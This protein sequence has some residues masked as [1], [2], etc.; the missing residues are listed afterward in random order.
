M[1]CNKKLN[2]FIHRSANT[3]KRIHETFSPEYLGFFNLIENKQKQLGILLILSI[4]AL[5]QCPIEEFKIKQWNQTI[6]MAFYQNLH[7]AE[8]H[9][10]ISNP[11]EVMHTLIIASV[12]E[13]SGLQWAA[14]WGSWTNW[15]NSS[16]TDMALNDNE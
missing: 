13:L 2:I 6:N 3:W 15:A 10:T 4:F 7:K 11:R 1:F 5:L 14:I 8:S 12:A 16:I 9:L